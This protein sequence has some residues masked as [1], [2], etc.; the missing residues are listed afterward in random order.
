MGYLVN[1]YDKQHLFSFPHGTKEYY[2]LLLALEF[3]SSDLGP[4]QGL[5]TQFYR[6]DQHRD[7]YGTQK[8]VGEV[9]RCYAI[10]DRLLEGRDY[11]V[12]EGQGKFTI[13]DMAFFSQ[14]GFSWLCGAAFLGDMSKW[15]HLRKWFVRIRD[16]KSDVLSKV[17][18]IPLAPKGTNRQLKKG[19]EED[20]EVKK[21]E[22]GLRAVLEEGRKE[23]GYVYQTA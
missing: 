15:P 10:L 16:D 23:F 9:E 2:D 21:R 18:E 3:S 4:A 11:I 1:K 20:A 6:L 7:P 14:L 19:Y 5:A 13:A 12:G 17:T 8:L 22:D